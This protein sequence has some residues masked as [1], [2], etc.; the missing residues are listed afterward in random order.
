MQDF[1]EV[2]NNGTTP[3]TLSDITIKFWADDSSGQNLV[4]HVWTGGCVTNVNGNP[5]CVHQVIG[6]TPTSTSFAACGPDPTHQ[7]NWEI[8]ISNT[9]SST[10]PPGAIWSN[11]QSALNLANYSNFAPGTAD[12]FSPCLTG[13]GYALDPHFA[14]YFRGSLVFSNGIDAPDC[15]APRGSQQLSGYV[16]APATSAPVVGAV[17]SGTEISLAIALPSQNPD[18][19]QTFVDQVSD[20]TNPLYRQYLTIPQFAATYG[21]LP[22]DYQ[23]LVTWAQ[24]YGLVVTPYANNLL[25]DVI[26]TAAQIEQALFVNL[27]L[28]TRP[29]GSQFYEPDREPS[30]CVPPAL[31]EIEGLDNYTLPASFADKGTGTAPPI[32]F[33]PPTPPVSGLFQGSD[34][35]SAYLG[36]GTTCSSLTGMGQQIG[37]AAYDGY[38]P[39]DIIAYEANTNLGNF[40]S[41]LYFG[42]V[43]PPPVPQPSVSAGTLLNG[44]N[45][46][47]SGGLGSLELALD[48]E[49]AIAMA[50]GAQVIPI[51]GRFPD[52][53]FSAMATLTFDGRTPRLRQISDSFTPMGSRIFVDELVAQ[54]QSIFIPSGDNAAYQQATDTCDC[55]CSGVTITEF[56]VCPGQCANQCTILRAVEASMTTCAPLPTGFDAAPF[57]FGTFADARSY[58]NITLT[59]GTNLKTGKGQSWKSEVTWDDGPNAASGGASGGGFVF[60]VPLPRFQRG[61]PNL[62]SVIERASPDVAAVAKNLYSVS[63]TCSTNTQFSAL[64]AIGGTCPGTLQP[65]TPVV[66]A[67][68]SASAPLWAGFTALMN[69]QGAHSNPI[70]NAVGYV[71]PLFYRFAGT[72]DANGTY[73]PNA[74][75]SQIFHDVTVGSNENKCSFGYDAL[76]GWDPTTGLG[77]PTCNLIETVSNYFNRP[78]IAASATETPNGLVLCVSG[79]QFPQGANV[80]IEYSGVPNGENSTTTVF[81][82]IAVPN[83]NGEFGFT[84]RS[85]G[86]Q[87]FCSEAVFSGIVTISATVTSVAGAPSGNT[88]S[89]T[90]STSL[91]CFSSPSG[92]NT[93][94]TTGPVCTPPPVSPLPA[95]A[96]GLTTCGGTCCAPENCQLG[97]DGQLV[98]CSTPLV[99][100]QCAS[101]TICLGVICG[102]ACCDG[103]CCSGTCCDGACLSNGG[104]CC[105]GNAC[106]T[107]CCDTDT[108]CADPSNSMCGDACSLGTA[109]VPVLLADG[110]SSGAQQCE[111]VSVQPPPPR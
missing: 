44:F 52:S 60:A 99:N 38:S 107:S 79:S 58:P 61:I 26:G 8:T 32:T 96:V 9:D 28:A 15:R 7:A 34:L 92:A 94:I 21:A 85:Q 50:P 17:P 98:C 2:I 105:P 88:V 51:E 10:L 47:P 39:I 103:S 110:G 48:I 66:A 77:S 64:P 109:P 29:D 35:R 54:G 83:A 90:V 102:G 31:E 36:S 5:S 89:T 80:E 70:Q 101:T 3:V 67:G 72:T 49:M 12:W 24:S 74:F 14:V 63:T 45:G 11:I 18:G 40:F 75:Y 30:L 73:I 56:P 23:Q 78:E 6:V 55:P 42:S 20:P 81:P 91:W 19:L 65:A 25:V 87:A 106:G 1:F 69:E 111:P 104:G 93:A 95:C 13:T 22:S 84:D 59:G 76:P 41:D 97:N 16:S 46:K 71:N 4:P 100:G 53:I 27:V 37:I 86:L 43:S 82:S 62:P 68:T 57:S 33:P 108:P